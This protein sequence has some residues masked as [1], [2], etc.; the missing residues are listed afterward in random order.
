MKEER[1]AD[2]E[3][4][5]AVLQRAQSGEENDDEQITMTDPLD[6][7]LQEAGIE[8]KS[9]TEKHRKPFRRGHYYDMYPRKSKCGN[10]FQVNYREN[11]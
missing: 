9:F 4:A 6:T 3:Q 10:L 7:T 1:Q 8:K 2:E 5:A 11:P